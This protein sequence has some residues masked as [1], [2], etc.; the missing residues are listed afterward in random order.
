MAML[1][2][3]PRLCEL[4]KDGGI[5]EEWLEIEAEA[6]AWRFGVTEHFKKK[7]GIDPTNIMFRL[8]KCF[9]N[10]I[11]KFPVESPDPFGLPL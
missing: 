3:D 6:D 11:L 8:K 1:A 5:S 4:Q 2:M 10:H 7:L 9:L